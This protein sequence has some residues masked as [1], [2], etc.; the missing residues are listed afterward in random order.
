MSSHYHNKGQKDYSKGAYKP[1]HSRVEDLIKHI[2]AGESKKERKERR[3][4]DDGHR[5]AKRQK[6][7]WW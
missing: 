6:S 1:P 2:V 5:H 3:A 4:Y 7:G